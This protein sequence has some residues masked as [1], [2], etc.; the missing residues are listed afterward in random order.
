M[1]P[2]L[3][4]ESKSK[5]DLVLSMCEESRERMNRYSEAERA[6]LERQGR[7]LM[8]TNVASRAPRPSQE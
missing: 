7:D 5:V 8:H 6:E 3:S 4:P 1:N 2:E